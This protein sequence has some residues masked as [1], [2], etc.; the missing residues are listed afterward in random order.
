MSEAA[1]IDEPTAEAILALG[2]RRVESFADLGGGALELARAL[3]ER[4]GCRIFLVDMTK[5][6]AFAE[7]PSDWVAPC[8]RMDE[9]WVPCAHNVESF[10]S[11]GVDRHRLV[12]VTGTLDFAGYTAEGHRLPQITADAYTFLSVFDWHLRKGWD[13]LVRAYAEAFGGRNDV[14]LV[15]KL[16][17]SNGMA[18]DEVKRIVRQTM[19]KALKKGRSLPPVHYVGRLAEADLPALYRSCRAFVLP[20]RGE[21]FGRPFA[22]AMAVGLPTIGT[23]WSGQVDFMNASNAYPIDYRLVPVSA[24]GVREVPN[25]RGHQ[26]A[27]PDPAHLRRLMLEVRDDAAGAE[28]RGRQAALDVRRLLSPAVVSAAIKERLEQWIRRLG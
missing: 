14:A 22:E 2:P 15:L 6:G 19:S 25:F 27:E 13:V 24:E 23:N 1:V 17:L 11:A 5:S 4:H 9:I 3:H 16:Q 10:A 28:A 7:V 12:V 18:L 26:W 20:T 8:N 21:G